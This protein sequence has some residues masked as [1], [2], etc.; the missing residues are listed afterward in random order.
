MGTL[1]AATVY[2]LT[3]PFKEALSLL[4]TAVLLVLFA[5]YSWVTARLPTA[6]PHLAGPAARVGA[7]GRA[8]RRLV[9]AGLLLYAA[10]AIFLA[11][12]PFAHGLVETGQALG[13]DEF[14]L[15]QWLAP[16]ASET[17]EGVIA[18]LFVWRG[19]AAAAMRTLVSSKVNQWT[20][21]VATLPPVFS[22]GA[23]HL[24]GMPLVARQRDELWLTAAQSFFAIVLISKFE[25]YRWEAVALLTPFLLQ[26]ALPPA[27]GGV[28]VHLAFALGYVLVGALLLLDRRRRRAIRSWP[29]CLRECIDAAPIARATWTSQAAEVGQRRP[30]RGVG[31]DAA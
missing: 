5:L 24:G 2:A 30:G 4:D 11:A 1:L 6:D 21:L 18:L 15:V 29:A 14:L 9:T 28:S 10:L 26:L 16:L 13:V 17:P 31:G 12:E 27:I 22:L 3:M 8:P 23:G 7:L 20:L 19:D 25:L